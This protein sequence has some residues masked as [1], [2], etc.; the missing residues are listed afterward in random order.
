M[1]QHLEAVIAHLRYQ[2][3]YLEYHERVFQVMPWPHTFSSAQLHM[4]RADLH[5]MRE[6]VRISREQVRLGLRAAHL[7]ALSKRRHSFFY[8]QARHLA[9]MRCRRP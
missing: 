3:L 1:A 2:E 7:A 9:A 5:F 4:L 6:E 8:K